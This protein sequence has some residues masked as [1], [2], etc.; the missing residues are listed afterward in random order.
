[1]KFLSRK[2]LVAVGGVLSVLLTE[3][4]GLSEEVALAVTDK[5]VTIVVAYLAGQ[6]LIDVV[7]AWLKR[8]EA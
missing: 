1:M 4:L 2:L 3:H 7:Y 6:S 5:L 8:R